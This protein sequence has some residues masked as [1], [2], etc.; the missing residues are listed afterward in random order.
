M[1]DYVKNADLMRAIMESKEKNQALKEAQEKMKKWFEN[2]L[3]LQQ[4]KFEEV[5]KETTETLNI[6]EEQLRKK[7]QEKLDDELR[8]KN[9]QVQ[10][11]DCAICYYL[12]RW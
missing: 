2:E 8:L 4:K 7:M 10:S 6:R 11:T 5:T 3:S 9:M 12:S 1:A